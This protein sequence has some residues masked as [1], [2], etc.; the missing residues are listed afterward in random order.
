MYV[1][2][3]TVEKAVDYC[4]NTPADG[5]YTGKCVDQ[6]IDLIKNNLDIL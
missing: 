6:R 5:L 1:A 3:T 2:R 4:L